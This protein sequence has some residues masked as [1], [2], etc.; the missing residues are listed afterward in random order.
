MKICHVSFGVIKHDSPADWLDSIGY[1][2]R[3]LEALAQRHEVISFH[4]TRRRACLV[5]NR[6]T[7]RF[8]EN[9]LKDKL[10]LTGL[11]TEL[12]SLAPDVFVLHGMHAVWNMFTFLSLFK[13]TRIFVQHHGEQVFSWPKSWFQRYNDRFVDGYFFSSG[14]MATP[15]LKLRQIA[16]T[17]KVFEMLEATSSFEPV[18][19]SSSNADMKFLWVGR[20]NANK[21]PETLIEGFRIFLNERPDAKLVVISSD[22]SALK[23][24]EESLGSANTSIKL[25]G[26]VDHREMQPWFLKANFIVSTSLYEG[27]GIAVLEAMSCGCIPIL[28]DI[29]SFRTMTNNGH[30]GFLFAAASAPALAAAL[31]KAATMDII[32][33]QERVHSHFDKHLSASAIANRF[34]QLVSD[35]I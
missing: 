25:I 5:R 27:S 24:L 6:V 17:K 29:P 19:R 7:Y 32:T 20:I 23:K 22:R 13:T 1:H 10:F 3:V 33:E 31:R 8:L 2:T 14:D 9:G 16:T 15:W 34:E 26:P 4:F 28:S 12:R 21:D 35:T 18:S 11:L 30:I